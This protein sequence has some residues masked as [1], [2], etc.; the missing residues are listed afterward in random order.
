M[1]AVSTT[2]SAKKRESAAAVAIPD[3]FVRCLGTLVRCLFKARE[4][5]VCWSERAINLRCA[6]CDGWRL[7]VSGEW[8]MVVSMCYKGILS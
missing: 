4:L 7:V 5:S 1:A 6:C 2:K 3:A 8:S